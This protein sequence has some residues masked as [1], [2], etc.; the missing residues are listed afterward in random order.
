MR[1][2]PDMD[3]KGVIGVYDMKSWDSGSCSMHWWL[4]CLAHVVQHALKL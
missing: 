1:C 4:S 2:K 3:E